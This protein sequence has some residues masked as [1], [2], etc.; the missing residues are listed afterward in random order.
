MIESVT[1][2]NLHEILPLIRSYQEFYNVAE[3]SDKRN[4][5][6]FAQFGPHSDAGCQFAFRSGKNIVAFAT[7]Y[8]SYSSSIASKTAVLNDLFTLPE[9]RRKGIGRSLIEH[10]WCYASSKGA[11]RLQWA[12]Q[13]DNKA[14]Q[15]LYRSIGATESSWKIFVYSP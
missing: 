9:A 3:I 6:F 4:R 11:V 10:C 15:S 2:K 14:A 12:T 5:E 1:E 13:V 8:F 7:V